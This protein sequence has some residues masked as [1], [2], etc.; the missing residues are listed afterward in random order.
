MFRKLILA[1]TLVL[2]LSF[3]WAQGAEDFETWEIPNSYS[4]A[5]FTDANGIT[6]NYVHCRNQGDYPIE[7]NGLMLRNASDS[8]LEITIPNGVGNFTFDY[9]K[10]YTGASARQLEIIVNGTQVATTPEYG[11]GS[12]ADA[13]THPF[14][15]D[16]NTPGNVTIKIKN[17]GTTTGNRQTTLDNIVWTGFGSSDPALF[18]SGTLNPFSAYVG[19]PSEAQSYTLTGLN[20]SSNI[21]VAAPAGYELSADNTT[22]TSTLSLASNYSGPVYV[23]LTG[24]NTGTFAGNITHSSGTVTGA[25]MEVTGEVLARIPTIIVDGSLS[26]FVAYEGTPSPVQ[27]YQLSS[28]FLTDNINIAAPAG[29]SISED[30]TTFSSN[31]SVSPSFEGPIY[32]RLDGATQGIFSGNI[33]HTSTGAAAVQLAV[34]GT[35]NEPMTAG[36]FLEEEFIYEP[37]TTLASNGWVA[38][39]GE[40]TNSPLVHTEGLM[41]TGYPLAN[42]YAGITLGNGEDVNKVFAG[43][44]ISEGAVYTSFLINVTNAHTS[45]EY[46]YHFMAPGSSSFRGRLFVNKNDTDQLR[47]GLTKAS[48]LSANAVA[49]T[50][51]DY[52]LNTTYLVVIKY[53]FMPEANDDIVTAWI[54]PPLSSVEP[55]PLLTADAT[56]SDIASIGAVA[57]RQSHANSTAIFDGIRVTNNWALLF[58]GEELPTPVLHAVGEPDPLYSIA[59][60]PS[61][62]ITS[63]T[64]YGVDTYGSINVTAPTHFEIATAAEGPWQSSLSLPADFNGLVYVRLNTA[65][66]GNHVGFILHNSLGAEEVSKRVEGEAFAPDVTWNSSV[67]ELNFTAEVN[68]EEPILSYT[69]SAT[70]ANTNLVLT[71]EGDAFSMRAG[72]SGEWTNALSLAPSFNG[73]I[74]VKMLTA[75]VGN[76][77]GSILHSTTNASEMTITLSGSVT[78]PG[79]GTYATDLF[80]SEYIEGSSSNKALEIFNGT[81]MPVDLSDYK[82][83]NYANGAATPNNTEI[84]SGILAHGEVFVIANSAA[85]ADILAI[86]D[87]TSTVTYF[88]GDDA[89]VLSKLNADSETYSY[90]DIIGVIGERPPG[91]AWTADGGYSTMDKTLVR[92]PTVT[93]GVSVNPSGHE[94]N[95]PAGFATLAT[96][97]DVYPVDTIDNL[98]SHL[99]DPEGT[100]TPADAP[101]ISPEGGLQSGPVTVSISS[102][103]PGAVIHYT[104]DGSTPDANSTVYTAP[105]VVST[106]TT[107]RAITIAP[108][109]TPSLVTSVTYSYATPVENIVTLRGMPTGANNFYQLTGE[110]ILT[111]QQSWRN[112]KYI[113]DATAAVLIDDNSGVITT[114]YNLYDGITGIVGTL[115]TYNNVL[116]FTPVF[117]PGAAT[118][119]GNVVVPEVRTLASLTSDDQAKLI[120]VCGVTI[121]ATNGNF[122]AG[123][124]S[125]TITDA[126]GS[127]TMR[128]FSPTDYNETPIPT[129]PVDLIC[130]AGQYRNTIQVSPRFLAD[131]LPATAQ[132]A[133]PVVQIVETNG[134]VTLSWEA[135]AGAVN[136]RIERSDD[137]YTGF[138]QVGTTPATSYSEA[139]TGTKLFYRVIA[140]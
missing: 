139:A 92:K 29:F 118:S 115:G 34:E 90:V 130:L 96:E 41:Y 68:A 49:W 2:A 45:G 47:F 108:G 135:V 127:L 79:G 39:S 100:A 99:F 30:N 60:A 125:I 112:Q 104:L 85:N 114:A 14:S 4:D 120:R 122:A 59:G 117:D 15:H 31:L 40:G 102:S 1:L 12:G 121:D 91:N 103:T 97:W 8:Y 67:T 53:E 82:V 51:Y 131:F 128:T 42:G 44:N 95:S 126:S 75:T 109:Y 33:N 76:F 35:V 137:P 123:V 111:Y 136:Y 132:L 7:G 52:A 72:T 61:E 22:F 62:E 87:I 86:A 124:E 13:T 58:D 17:I 81:G 56:E 18:V 70:G 48:N 21:N 73:S 38:H 77:Q 71:L 106:T 116:Q 32:V 78:P 80:F 36:I 74:Y 129:E 119:S 37:G 24:A 89:V 23:R 69:L 11:A 107:V 55:A 105:F 88:N 6:W 134:T 140:E 26:A 28:L 65:V 94:P 113:Q 66:E 57:I 46:C 84:L 63:Y 64:L 3:V 110:A 83:E 10:A 43:G 5:T 9:R 27:S 101:V 19:D 54:N 98:G 25:N 133:A 93:Q 16:I 20:L 50:E 138:V